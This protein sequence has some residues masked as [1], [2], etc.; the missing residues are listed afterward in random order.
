MRARSRHRGYAPWRGRVWTTGRHHS[1]LLWGVK[2][3]LARSTL[4]VSTTSSRED[5]PLS[6][7]SSLLLARLPQGWRLAPKRVPSY[8][9][10]R[11]GWVIMGA[12]S[13]VGVSIPA[14]DASWYRTPRVPRQP[15]RVMRRRHP[16]LVKKPTRSS[17][18]AP[19][20]RRASAACP[21]PRG[22]APRSWRAPGLAMSTQRNFACKAS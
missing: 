1:L 21:P 9:G 20:A 11:R 17:C 6:L 10:P 4:D 18:S 7:S 22:L 16:L 5:F 13:N 19:T 15:R 14:H 8:C 3:D 2:L 12:V